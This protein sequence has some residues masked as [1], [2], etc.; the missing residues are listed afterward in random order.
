[1]SYYIF[2]KKCM[3]SS[4]FRI[5]QCWLL[6]FIFVIIS[7][8]E[9]IRVISRLLHTNYVTI[10]SKFNVRFSTISLHWY[11]KIKNKTIGSFWRHF[12][13]FSVIWQGLWVSFVLVD[14][15]CWRKKGTHHK[16]F[17][18]EKCTYHQRMNYVILITI[19]VRKIVYVIF[20]R[21]FNH[22]YCINGLKSGILFI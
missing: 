18:I 15:R 1:M 5:V 3:K 19:G 22:I 21:G 12:W 16:C 20:W 9:L 8:C 17:L 14:Q 7:I 6:K 10:S 11:I 2:L 4:I 13:R